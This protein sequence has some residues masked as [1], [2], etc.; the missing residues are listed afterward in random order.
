MKYIFFAIT[1]LVDLFSHLLVFFI[2]K[3]FLFID[4]IESS[5]IL[6]IFL[7]FSLVMTIIAPLLLNW[8]DHIISRSLYLVVAV[9]IGL[10]FNFLALSAIF[11]TIKILIP[12]LAEFRS[13]ALLLILIFSGLLLIWEYLS[14]KTLKERVYQVKIKDL[15]D[16]WRG[17][18]LLHLSDLHLGPIWRQKRYEKILRVVNKLNADLVCITGD[19]FDGLDS[20]FSWFTELKIK[21]KE[22]VFY[23]HGNH[24][25]ILGAKKVEE[26]LSSSNIKILDNTMVEIKGLQII[27]LSCYYQ[28]RLDVKGKILSNLNYTEAKPSIMLYHEPKDIDLARQ[29]G[30]DLQLSGHTH[31]GQFFPFNLIAKLLF[32]GFSSGLYQLAGGFSLS[33]SAGAGTW[34]PPL[35]LFTKSEYS[36]IELEKLEEEIS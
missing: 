11:F 30:I 33:L 26:L 36:L 8:K 12:S 20:D 19:L 14:A 2:L 32:T 10:A 3:Y 28:G 18:K 22:G 13:L 25:L 21:A 31:G 9:Y 27:G 29:A 35:R 16:Y 1:A 6:F 17:K 15:P 23:S 4:N 7:A 5:L 24:D 34:G